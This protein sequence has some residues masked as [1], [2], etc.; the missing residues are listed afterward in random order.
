MRRKRSEGIGQ[1]PLGL[2][3]DQAHGYLPPAQELSRRAGVEVQMG[4][5]NS[6]A[7]IPDKGYWTWPLLKLRNQRQNKERES[8]AVGG[9][10]SR[11]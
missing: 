9:Q 2:L 6:G 5:H 8:L 3:S 11:E 7:S 10:G 1:T 4:E